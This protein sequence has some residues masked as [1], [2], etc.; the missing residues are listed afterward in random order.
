MRG[1]RNPHRG[2]EPL[3]RQW[4]RR[5]FTLVELIVAITIMLVLTTMALPLVQIQVQRAKEHQLRYDLHQMR[6][7]I[8]RY[9]DAADRGLFQVQFGSDGYPPTLA[10]LVE[11]IEANGKTYRFLR[12]VPVDPMTGDKDWGLLSD[13]DAPDADAWGGQNVFNVYSRSQGTGMNGVPYR[14]W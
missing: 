13:S 5:G 12:R 1:S 10:A 8:D 14:D 4:R 2:A 11:P 7:A 6:A 3:R 9:K